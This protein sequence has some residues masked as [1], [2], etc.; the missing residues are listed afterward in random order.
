MYS[1]AI[2]D[3]FRS[4]YKQDLQSDSGARSETRAGT[5]IAAIANHTGVELPAQPHDLQSVSYPMRCTSACL[6]HEM[7]RCL[8]KLA[9]CP[10][11]LHQHPAGPL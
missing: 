8:T 2:H 3:R 9:G 10:A 1:V 6:W 4:P 11:W 7:S 5:H